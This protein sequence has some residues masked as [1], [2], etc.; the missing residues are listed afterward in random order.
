[1]REIWRLVGGDNAID[2]RRA[3]D[4][5]CVADGSVELSRRCRLKSVAATSPC[6]HRKIRIGKFDAL[7]VRGQTYGLGFERYELQSDDAPLQPEV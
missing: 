6:E 2:D 4:F 3:I 5:K 7:L 1:M